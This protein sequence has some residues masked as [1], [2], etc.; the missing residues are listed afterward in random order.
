MIKNKISTLFLSFVLCA[1]LVS[2]TYAQ[3]GGN[4]GGGNHGGDDNGGGNHGGDDN[5]DGGSTAVP[6]NGGIMYLFGAAV[7]LGSF[8]LYKKSRPALS[9]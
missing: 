3:R 2:P 7:I 5:D 9:K 8:V 4:H 6:I 1:A